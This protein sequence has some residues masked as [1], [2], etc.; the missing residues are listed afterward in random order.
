MASPVYSSWNRPSIFGCIAISIEAFATF[1]STFGLQTNEFCFVP[2]DCHKSQEN[3]SISPT[4]RYEASD[5]SR[6]IQHTS[7][8]GSSTRSAYTRSRSTHLGDRTGTP[9]PRI[10]PSIPYLTTSHFRD[11]RDRD[12]GPITR[13]PTSPLLISATPRSFP[14][15]TGVPFSRRVV[16][17]TIFISVISHAPSLLVLFTTCINM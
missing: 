8:D 13:F 1:L 5:T 6:A 4:E 12:S 7:Y 9:R 2:A 10:N 11:D 14:Q 17:R 16:S 15:Q 3:H